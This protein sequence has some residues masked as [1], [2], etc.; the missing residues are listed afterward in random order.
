MAFT[1]LFFW[2]SPVDFACGRFPFHQRRSIGGAFAQLNVVTVG[3][4]AQAHR[5]AGRRVFTENPAP[6]APAPAP[7]RI[8]AVARISGRV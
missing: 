2:P 8:V 7:M 3:A 4:Y 6:F 1:R 5:Q